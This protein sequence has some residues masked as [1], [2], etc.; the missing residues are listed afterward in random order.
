MRRHVLVEVVYEHDDWDADPGHAGGVDVLELD[1]PAFAF[2]ELLGV[3]EISEQCGI[4][5]FVDGDQGGFVMSESP[6]LLSLVDAEVGADLLDVLLA[7]EDL[8]DAVLDLRLAHRRRPIDHIGVDPALLLV[9]HPLEE[10][11]EDW[12]VAGLRYHPDGVLLRYRRRVLG[13]VLAAEF[14]KVGFAE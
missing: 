8:L 5:A 12:R 14:Q 9:E 10:I 11:K 13:N 7:R 4:A 3:R 1:Y 2:E 6:E